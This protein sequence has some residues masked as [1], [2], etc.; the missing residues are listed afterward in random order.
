MIA[1]DYDGDGRLDVI[2]DHSNSGGISG[3]VY[4]GDGSGNFQ[5][6]TSRF[7]TTSV[8]D[9]N[10]D[11]RLDYL[12]TGGGSTFVTNL[13]ID[14][15][16]HSQPG[17]TTPSSFG[18][19]LLTIQRI[20]VADYDGD[21]S[22]DVMTP[23]RS[24]GFY[25]LQ[26]WRSD[27]AGLLQSE[28]VHSTGAGGITDIALG[29]FDGDSILDWATAGTDNVITAASLRLPAAT[30]ISSTTFPYSGGVSPSVILAGISTTT[31]R[32]I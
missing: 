26:G 4:L 6:L 14:S 8:G 21:G 20:L 13:S 31:V 3:A 1:A 10:R 19:G 32:P 22:P 17:L 12:S 29:D 2:V 28:F 18:G 25:L 11:G 9:F 5:R 23:S 24:L 7:A 15:G 16:T 30:V 27:G